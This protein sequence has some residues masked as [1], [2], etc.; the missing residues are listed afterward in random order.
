RPTTAPAPDTAHAAGTIEGWETMTPAQGH[1]RVAVILYSRTA[2]MGDPANNIQTP[3]NPPPNVCAFIPGLSTGPCNWQMDTRT[4]A[5][6]H[7][8]LIFDGDTNGTPFDTTDDIIV[9]NG[10]AIK[11]GIDLAAAQNATGEVLTPVADVEDATVTF[12]AAPNGLDDMF[13]FPALDL[14]D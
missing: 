11:T 13:A 8:A 7:I 10:F 14:G 12:P 6:A 2:D 5:Q 1:Y 4:G 3:G 9:A